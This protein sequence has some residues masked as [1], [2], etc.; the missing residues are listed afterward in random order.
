MRV[1]CFKGKPAAAPLSS[2]HWRRDRVTSGVW[3]IQLLL[4][5][6]EQGRVWS[7]ITPRGT[8]PRSCPFRQAI[9]APVAAEVIQA[10]STQLSAVRVDT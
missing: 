3:I 1:S 5:F 8:G 9:A 6:T 10:Q 4:T 7:V 2:V